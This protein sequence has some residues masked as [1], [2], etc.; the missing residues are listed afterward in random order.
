VVELEGSTTVPPAPTSKF[1]VPK[2]NGEVW[3]SVIG[4]ISLAPAAV[5]V[6]VAEVCAIN[7]VVR[8]AI[9]TIT[10]NNINPV[11]FILILF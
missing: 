1:I 8:P 10:A 11:F 5:P 6:T 7:E 9:I 2:C 4:T 3:V